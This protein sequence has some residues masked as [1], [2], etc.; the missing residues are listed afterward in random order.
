MGNGPIKRLDQQEA[1]LDDARIDS[2]TDEAGFRY[3]RVEELPLDHIPNAEFQRV[4]GAGEKALLGP[5]PAPATPPQPVRPAAGLPSYLASLYELPLLTREQEVHLF[6]KMNYLK[7]KASRLVARLDPLRPD[8]R[9]LDRIE[10]FYRQ[11]VDVKNEIIRANLRL[12]V[13]MTKRYAHGTEPLFER[14]SDGNISLMRAVEKFDYARGFRFSTYATWVLL[15]NFAQ[16]VSK[17]HR[18]HARFRNGCEDVFR[19]V[20]DQRTNE[21]LEVAA[22]IRREAAIA[23]LLE[24]L[25]DRER[26]IIRDRYG[27]DA[28]R[29]AMT[30]KELGSA[31]GVSK[32]RV[33]QLASRAILKLRQAAV[34]QGLDMTPAD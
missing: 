2:Y 20:P 22:Q 29:E 13:A 1:P 21:H 9:L 14:V 4:G 26:Q 6:R 18:D 7:Y 24:Q 32:E 15:R 10:E 5:A 28:G 31:M 17:G 27:L 30:L 16:G 12:V 19:A 3:H 23:H 11:S 8:N 33:R 34:A 25:D